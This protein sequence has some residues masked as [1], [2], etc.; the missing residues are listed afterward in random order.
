MFIVSGQDKQK[1]YSEV[2]LDKIK[3]RQ[4]TDQMTDLYL[5]DARDNCNKNLN[6]IEKIIKLISMENTLL[7]NFIESEGLYDDFVDYAEMAC[8]ELEQFK[9]KR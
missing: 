9:F 8:E 1:H 2:L 6:F 4:I 3:S 7:K 5:K